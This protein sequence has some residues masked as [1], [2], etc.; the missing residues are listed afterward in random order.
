MSSDWTFRKLSRVSAPGGILST[1]FSNLQDVD[2]S[3]DENEFQYEDEL[4]EI[5]NETDV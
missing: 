4:N 3:T 5:V 1:G 2:T